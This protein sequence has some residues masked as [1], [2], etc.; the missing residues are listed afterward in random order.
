MSDYVAPT[1]PAFVNDDEA[2]ENA[3]QALVKGLTGLPGDHVRPRWQPVPALE[4]GAFTDWCAVGVRDEEA[5]TAPHIRHMTTINAD[6]T[7]RG[8]SIYQRNSRIDVLASFY[9]PNSR[10]Y[11]SLLR[12]GVCVEGN[13]WALQAA[14]LDVEAG[15]R[16]SRFPELVGLEW[17]NRIDLAFALV[18]NSERIYPIRDL[19]SAPIQLN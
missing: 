17:R 16:M 10:G 6:P 18:R 13:R 5:D 9:G 8:Q 7:Q 15:S 1:A 11:A 4:L 2:L 3:L 14:G 19:I 12:D